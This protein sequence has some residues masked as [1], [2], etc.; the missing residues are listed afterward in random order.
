MPATGE[1]DAG[2]FALRLGTFL[3]DLVEYDA[4]ASQR[5]DDR[6]RNFLPFIPWM[7]PHSSVHTFPLGRPEEAV[8]VNTPDDLQM[9]ERYLRGGH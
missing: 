9:M 6:E 7:A 5:A 1:S 2:L 3:H 4:D 8:G